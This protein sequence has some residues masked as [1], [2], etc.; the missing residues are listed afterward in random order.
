MVVPLLWSLYYVYSVFFRGGKKASP[1]TTDAVNIKLGVTGKDGIIV[2]LA[3]G[4]EQSVERVAVM[5]W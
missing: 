3:F 4:D 1:H 2:D 5:E